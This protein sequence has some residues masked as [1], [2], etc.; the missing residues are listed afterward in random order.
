MIGQMIWERNKYETKQ[1]FIIK[2][3]NSSQQSTPE[4][5]IHYEYVLCPKRF[6]LPAHILIRM[7]QWPLTTHLKWDVS[8]CLGKIV[9]F[10][11]VPIVQMFP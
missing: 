5:K 4:P 7:I 3:V 6:P 11:T 2:T 8:H 10:Q 9:G 1:Y